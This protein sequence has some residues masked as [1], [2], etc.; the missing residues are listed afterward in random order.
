MNQSFFVKFSSAFLIAALAVMVLPATPVSAAG[1]TVNTN[2]DVVAANGACSLRE[3]IINANNDA[4]INADCPG[5]GAYGNDTITFDAAVTTITLV[6]ALPAINDG[7]GDNDLTINGG[8]TVTVDGGGAFR[9]FNVAAGTFTLQNITLTNGQV[10]GNGGAVLYAGGEGLSVDTVTFESNRTVTTAANDGGAIYHNAGTLSIANSTFN[11]NY[12]EDNGGAV[13]IAN[14]TGTMTITNSV[15]TN[16]NNAVIDDGGA[17]YLNAGTLQIN[18][19]NFTNNAATGAA[20]GRGG[21]IYQNAGSLTVGNTSSVTFANNSSVG[22]GGAI[23]HNAGSM[24]ITGTFTGNT[25][26]FG[27]ALFFTTIADTFTV[28]NSTFTSNRALVGNAG[29]IRSGGNL[30]ITNSTFTDNSAVA[31]GGVLWHTTNSLNISNSTFG[32]AGAGNYAIDGGALYIVSGTGTMTINNSNFVSQNNALIDDAAA[33]YLGDGTLEINGGSF[34]NNTA[35]GNGGALVV[36]NPAVLTIGNTS[37]VTFT[38]NSA[39]TGGGGAIYHNSN[40]AFSVSNSTF[41]NNSAPAVNGGA[42]IAA[43]VGSS[44]TLT[45]STF[46]G[47]SSADDGGALV[48]QSEPATI[49]NSI[50]QNNSITGTVG[51]ADGGAILNTDQADQTTIRLSTFTNNS[52]TNSA[53]NNARGGAIANFGANFVLANVTFS[54]NSVNETGAAAGN[55]QGGALWVNDASTIHNVTFSNNSANDTGTGIADGGTV[56]QAAGTLTIANSILNNGTENGASANCGGVI[57]DGGNNISYPSADCG[58]GFT[59]SDP[60]LQAL[61][62]SPAYFPLAATSPAIN[63]GS[64]AVCATAS[65]TNNESQNGLTRP[66][67]VNCEIG[68]YETVGNTAPTVQTPIVDVAVNED[69]ANTVINLFNHFQDT[70]SADNA[71]TYTVENNTNPGLFSSVDISTPNAFTL[72]YLA[73]ANGTADITIRATDPGGLFVEDT[74][75]VNVTPVND[76]PSFTVGA[77]QTVNED[78]GAQ[79]VSGWATGISAGPADESG[80]LLNFSASND[81]NPLFSVQPAV[82]AD[83]TLTYTPAP[84]ANGSATVTLTLSDNGGVLNGGVDT[85]AP[86]T[87]TITVTAVDDFPTATDDNAAVNEDD[88]A[89]VINVLSNDND[90]EGNPIAITGITQPANGTSTNNGTDVSYQPDPN[91]CGPDSF[92]YTLNGGSTATVNVTV[93]CDDD[94]PVAVNDLANLTEDDPATVI[95]ILS[96]DTDPDGGLMQVASVGAAANGTVTN[97]TTN[98]SYQPDADFCGSDSFTY[99]LNGGSTATVNVSVACVD[100]APTAVDDNFTVP[101]NTTSSLNVLGNDTDPDAGLMEV[102]SVTAPANGTATDNNSNVS[103]EPNTGYCGPDSFTYTLNGGSTATVTLDV[104]CAPAFTSADN[105]SFDFGFPDSFAISATGTPSLMTITVTGS[106]PAGIT[107]TDNGDG[108]ASLDGDGSTPAGVYTFILTANNGVNPS[109]IQNFTLTIRNGPTPTTVGSTPDT[110]NGSISENESIANTLGITQISVEFNRDVYDPAGDADPDDVTNPANYRLLRNTTGS[111][112]TGSCSGPIGGTDVSISVDTVTYSDGGG[113]GPFIATLNINSGLPLNVDGFYRLIVCGTTSIVD[114]TN[115]NL[116]LAG[117][118]ITPGTDFFRNFRI[119]SPATGGGDDDDNDVI[120]AINRGGVVIPVTGFTPDRVTDLPAQ[121]TAYAESGLSLEIPALSLNLPI[122][123]VDFDGSTWDVTWLGRNA[124]Y[125]EGSAYPTWTG[126]TVLTGHFTDA[127]GNP[128]PFAFIQEL[129]TGDKVYVHNNG[130]VYVYEV[131]RSSLILP[132]SIKT[133]FKHEED[134]WLSIVTC[135]NFNEKTEKFSNRRLVRAVLISIIPE[136]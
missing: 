87:F 11:N 7:G 102:A 27:G 121:S 67:G 22:N 117:N 104:V 21:A 79:S 127:N 78:A 32:S 47:N 106:L 62:G 109:A 28:S 88:L 68:S 97:N 51:N 82:A 57:T 98:V 91:Y 122:V 30:T 8:G 16:Q 24:A 20:N 72:D 116:V 29:A 9:I 2:A 81:N 96:N 64:N 46:T 120:N 126:N 95:N 73:N 128:G 12:T 40:S 85:S 131:R 112:S 53:D 52:V 75:T 38:G 115:T 31:N 90:P 6:A 66:Q 10:N 23:T 77:D 4:N 130:F 17:I 135:E 3:A 100:D 129:K 118:G 110:G 56:F 13:Y 99:T 136:K 60:Q 94:S 76:A 125:L 26:S 39:L 45:N 58:A 134:T 37:G 49:T 5:G 107:L 61:T 43:S 50:F 111:F 41:T 36:A 70:E 119:S 103:Y 14:G 59:N 63:A 86:Q 101:G 124:G 34:V 114:A 18:G 123:G 80:Q 42:I 71:L 108:T 69:A 74:F 48:I 15:F 92:T 83:G 19:G 33:A 132:S 1:L 84:N 113:S 25:A 54:G 93:N 133:L 35:T 65:S 44:F 105:T 55:A 89:T